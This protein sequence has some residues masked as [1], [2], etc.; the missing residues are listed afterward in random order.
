MIK[1]KLIALELTE[2]GTTFK[3]VEEI[4]PQFLPL[5]FLTHAQKA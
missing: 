5:M 4:T 3:C 1:V 2:V